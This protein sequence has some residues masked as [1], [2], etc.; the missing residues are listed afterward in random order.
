MTNRTRADDIGQRCTSKGNASSSSHTKKLSRGISQ[1]LMFGKTSF[2]QIK[3]D[4]GEY[5]K[6]FVSFELFSMPF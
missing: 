3:N 2:G 5:L 1:V 6:R 4:V